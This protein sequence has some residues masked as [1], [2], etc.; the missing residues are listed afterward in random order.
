[1]LDRAFV[2]S[3]RLYDAEPLDLGV[4]G[5]VAL[6]YGTVDLLLN[7][8]SLHQLIRTYGADVL[9][10][11]VSQGYV[12]GH[13]SNQMWTAFTTTWPERE[14]YKPVTWSLHSYEADVIEVFRHATE[15][16]G[17]G[18]RKAA[19]FLDA[20]Q[21][22]DFAPASYEEIRANFANEPLMR[23]LIEETTLHV[24]GPDEGMA[25]SVVDYEWDGEQLRFE[26]GPTWP[27]LQAVYRQRRADELNRGHLLLPILGTL[28]DLQLAS[29][30][31][32]EIS[33]G[34]LGSR[35]LQH[36]CIE[37]VGTTA[38]HLQGIGDFQRYTLAGRDVRGAINSGS[39][40]LR[41]LME[42][43]DRA[44]KF[45]GWIL[46][47]PFE[48]DLLAEYIAEINRESWVASAPAKAIRFAVTTMLPAV[49]GGTQ[50]G[51]EAGT[52]AGLLGGAADTFLVEKI[53][54]GWRPNQF[55]DQELDPFV[56]N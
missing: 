37:L 19:A 25:V 24:L 51:V 10:E 26:L 8:N 55:V 20:V 52:A 45:K 47:Q 33:T 23:R 15:K 49:V 17:Y 28:T 13:Y 38:A 21:P 56:R 48:A 16:S 46:S 7:R 44:Q 27:K 4:L 36:K 34:S 54:G 1:M 39:Q 31:G 2:Q 14:L 40:D 12:R 11:F 30:F 50:L 22:L 3:H 9:V 5:E 43:L 41:S 53:L 29:R 42:L 6:F 18:R 32:A 35:L